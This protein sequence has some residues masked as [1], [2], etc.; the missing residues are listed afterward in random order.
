MRSIL[1]PPYVTPGSSQRGKDYG[2]KGKSNEQSQVPLTYLPEPRKGE[3]KE[4]GQTD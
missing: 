1:L 3:L 2:R 4:N